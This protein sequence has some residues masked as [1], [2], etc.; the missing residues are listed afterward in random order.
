[1]TDIERL[2]IRLNELSYPDN[3]MPT[4]EIPDMLFFQEVM[5]HIRKMILIF[6]IRK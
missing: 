3:M 1:M 5:A 4:A 6:P 2:F